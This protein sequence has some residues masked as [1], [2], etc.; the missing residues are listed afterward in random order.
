MQG[1][2]RLGGVDDDSLGGS[3]GD[4]GS[5]LPLLPPPPPPP[6]PSAPPPSS[7]PPDSQ[8]WL[9]VRS[10]MIGFA[11]VLLASLGIC[12]SLNVQKYVHVKNTNP[13]TGQP[14]A[15]FLTLRLWWVGCLM[16]AASE[17]VRLRLR[18]RHI[19]PACRSVRRDGFACSACHVI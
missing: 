4:V 12:V 14:D 9:D 10:D 3:L 19:R 8:H 15:N 5:G 2:T 18:L 17:L 1:M 7:P 13:V 11:L 6:P 16:N